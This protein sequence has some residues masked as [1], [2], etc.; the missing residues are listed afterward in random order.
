MPNGQTQMNQE[1]SARERTNV[2]VER[3]GLQLA[4]NYNFARSFG[5]IVS[6]PDPPDQVGA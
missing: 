5:K 1:S 2:I 4:I 6:R 3:N